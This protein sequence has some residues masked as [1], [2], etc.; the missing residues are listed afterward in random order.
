[1]Y[2]KQ[3]YRDWYEKTKEQR[4]IWNK[5]YYQKHKERILGVHK[6]WA[7]KKVDQTGS[8]WRL[9]GRRRRNKNPNLDKEYRLRKKARLMSNSNKLP[10]LTHD[11]IDF[12]SKQKL[13]DKILVEIGAGESTLY[14]E[15]KFNKVISYEHN[16]FYFNK[17]KKE[18]KKDTTELNLFNMNILSDKNFLENIKIA[19]YIIIDNDNRYMRRYYFSQCVV[20]HKKK[21]SS[22]ILDNGL[23][24]L[25]AY[26]Y[27]RDNFFVKDFPGF[28]KNKELTVTSIFSVFKDPKYYRKNKA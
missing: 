26:N 8:V 12:F 25:N 20:K 5:E 19:D 22:I 14:W 23:W 3:Q 10:L 2:N 17:I 11:F 24:N 7:E 16:P 1:M 28:N 4:Q 9:Y 18:L 6:A 13:K 27:L 15:E 21:T